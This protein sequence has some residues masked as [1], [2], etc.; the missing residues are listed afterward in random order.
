[1]SE[2][3]IFTSWGRTRQPKNGAEVAFSQNLVGN[4]NYILT[5]ANTVA[6]GNSWDRASEPS[7]KGLTTENQRYLHLLVDSTTVAR[8]NKAIQ[9]GILGYSHAFGIW[10]TLTAIDKTGSSQAYINGAVVTSDST[11]LEVFEIFGVDKILLYNNNANAD[12]AAADHIVRAG[13]STF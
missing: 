13:F 11:K 8:G 7:S 1:M 12:N 3:R 2:F 10:T 6:N 5:H 4:E 9:I